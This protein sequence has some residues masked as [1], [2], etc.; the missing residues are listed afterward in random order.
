[1]ATAAEGPVFLPEFVNQSVTLL[2]SG[3]SE[4]RSRVAGVALCALHWKKAKQNKKRGTQR[5]L[6]N[7][8]ES[9]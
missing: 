2:A 7:L 6:T 1:M 9:S 4:Y 3:G 8:F 5:C